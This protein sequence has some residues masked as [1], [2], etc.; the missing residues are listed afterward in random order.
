MASNPRST[1]IELTRMFVDVP[2][3]VHTPPNIPANERGNSSF[4]GLTPIRPDMLIITGINMATAAVLLMKA[5]IRNTYQ[6]QYKR[7]L[8]SHK[9]TMSELVSITSRI[10]FVAISK[11]K[12]GLNLYQKV[13][14]R[15]V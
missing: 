10:F 9:A 11:S 2:I 15:I 12:I 13:L 1:A 6:N 8:E 4:E 3:S 7:N 5:E 14:L